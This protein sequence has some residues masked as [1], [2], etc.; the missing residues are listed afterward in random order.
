MRVITVVCMVVAILVFVFISEYIVV[1]NFYDE[2]RMN[3]ENMKKTV[4][5]GIMRS[6]DAQ[7]IVTMWENS[8][9]RLYI[10]ENHEYFKSLEDNI[11]NLKF[12]TQ[13]KEQR[14]ILYVLEKLIILADE[15]EFDFA[16]SPGNIF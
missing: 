8:K 3:A 11:Y 1:E 7:N 2:L 12:S 9:G 5:G 16:L 13:M 6:D 14:N 4:S 10:F 15:S